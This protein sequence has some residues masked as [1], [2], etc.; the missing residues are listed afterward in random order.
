LID[1]D[2][3]G[4]IHSTDEGE[5]SWYDFALAIKKILNLDIKIEK[6]FKGSFSKKTE[7]LCSRKC[8]F[9]KTV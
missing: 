4:I 3:S 9:E 6:R 8:S 1:F 2:I 7:V 5:T